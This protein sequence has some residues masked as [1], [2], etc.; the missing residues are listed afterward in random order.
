MSASSWHF[1]M[2]PRAWIFDGVLSVW[3]PVLP[4]LTWSKSSLPGAC[5][6]YVRIIMVF[7]RV[8]LVELLWQ[9]TMGWIPALEYMMSGARGILRPRPIMPGAKCHHFSRP[10]NQWSVSWLSLKT[11]V[12]EGFSVWASK[13]AVLVW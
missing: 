7:M 13:L 12:V 2:Y 11:K 8:P 4:N 9:A 3:V 5:L 6:S 1:C 10:Q